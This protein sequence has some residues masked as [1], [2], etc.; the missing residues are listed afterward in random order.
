MGSSLHCH[1]SWHLAVVEL[2]LGNADGAWELYAAWIR[3]GVVPAPPI[4]V[5]TDTTAFL[6]RFELRGGRRSAADWQSVRVLGLGKAA[7]AS[8]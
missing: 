1:L 3:P 5:V 4:N 6:W 8:L 7:R 2:A